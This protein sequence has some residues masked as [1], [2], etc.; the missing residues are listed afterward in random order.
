MNPITNAK[1]VATGVSQTRYEQ[2]TEAR[3]LAGFTVRSHVL[4][5]IIR[6]PQ[7]WRLGYESPESKSKEFGSVLDCLALT[8]CDWPRRFCV[9]PEDAPRRP[10][11]RQ[12][13]AKK[14]SPETLAAIE[15][16]DDF[17][18]ST[19]GCEIIT[20]AVNASVHV[21]LKR[22]EN[23]EHIWSFLTAGH[24][25]A[26]VKGSYADKATGLVIP[27]KALIDIVPDRD[28]PIYGEMLGDLKTT[29][30]AAPRQ[31]ARDCYNY[32]YHMAA[33]WY[34]DHWNAAT[35][36]ERTEFVHVVVENYAP[37]ECRMPVLSQRFLQY[38]RLLYQKALSVY[39]QCLSTGV[40]PS[41]DPVNTLWPITDPEEW[42]LT[43][44][45]LY[46]DAR[47]APEPEEE[48]EPEHET[49]DLIP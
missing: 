1:V 29:R 7:R 14:P 32:R 2:E 25:Q 21:A 3:G 19:K 31:F 10:S 22:L 34:L 43:A 24:N 6:N 18:E 33:A 5:E 36:E 11:D 46:G 47:F 23:E 49:A 16:W 15:W 17:N 40:W 8:P 20:P 41:Y 44:D 48:E 12:R 28:H 4:S 9:L 13:N 27:T 45:E 30:N 38:G 26:W 37:H 35:G 42:M 39:C